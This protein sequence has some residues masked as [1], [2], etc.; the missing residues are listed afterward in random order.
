MMPKVAVFSGSDMRTFGGGEKYITEFINRLSGFDV[1]IFSYKGKEPFRM[2]LEQVRKVVKADIA[3]YN[4]PE[5]PIAKERVMLTLSG[6]ETLRKLKAFDVVYCLDNSLITNAC[7]M[8]ASKIYG[9]KYILGI[10]DAN[11][12]RTTPI[13]KTPFRSFALSAYAHIRN[14]GLLSAPNIRVVNHSDG[15]KLR[16]L[17]YK[18]RLYSITDFINVKYDAQIHVDPKKF[19]VL[20]VGRLNTAHKG[21]D[22]LRDIIGKTLKADGEVH[23]KIIGSGEDGEVI[24][25]V[26]AKTYPKNVQWLG[27]VKEDKLIEEYSNASLLIFPSRFESFGLSLAEGQGYGLPAIAF[28]VRGPNVIMRDAKQGVLVKPFDTTAFS[29]SIVKYHKTWIK[30]KRAYLKLKSEVSKIVLSRFGEK[31]IMPKLVSMLSER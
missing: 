20:F 11:I 13:K 14:F 24:V 26:L 9:F 1:T 17:G 30:D 3:Y 7:L 15:E 19:V 29:S 31:E 21:I 8:A 25:K 18:G 16:E 22:L 27:F 23:F 10:H 5:I 6:I 12:L 4:A 28:K 2:S